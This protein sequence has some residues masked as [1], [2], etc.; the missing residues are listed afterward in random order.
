MPESFEAQADFGVKERWQ[1]AKPTLKCPVCQIVLS[2]ALTNDNFIYEE[3]AIYD[4]FDSVCANEEL[5]GNWL[6]QENHNVN[7]GAAT[8]T[9]SM[10]TKRSYDVVPRTA[11]N[12]PE[13]AE[14]RLREKQEKF[15]AAGYKN[16]QGQGN[17]FWQTHA[18]K[19]LC[20]EAVKAQDDD[21]KDELLKFYKVGQTKLEEILPKIAYGMCR[22]VKHMYRDEEPMVSRSGSKPGSIY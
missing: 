1:S 19:E 9:T 17:K 13:V 21:L 6:I 12:D 22:K 4:F 16:P 8:R 11:S 10:K 14:K 7:A 3:D 5:F 18:M 15:D 2:S 20:L